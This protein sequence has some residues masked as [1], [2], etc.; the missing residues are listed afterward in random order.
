MLYRRKTYEIDP[1]VYEVFT[2]FFHTYLLPNQLTHGAKLLGRWVNEEK[3]EIMALW[4]YRDREHYE[5]VE[6]GIRA[7]EMHQQAQETR[8]S[9]PRLFITSNETFFTPTGNYE[10][11]KH[12]VS[13][14]GY[15]VNDEGHVLL[16]RNN[17]RH[18]TYEMPGG[19]VEPGET[20]TAALHR[21]V[22]EETGVEAEINEISGVYQNITSGIICIVYKGR[23][24]SGH[25]APQPPETN[26]VRFVDLTKEKIEDWVK[27]PQFE[28]RLRDAHNAQGVTYESFEVRP[29]RLIE[30]STVQH[31]IEV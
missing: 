15:I 11:S 19:Q 25:A 14:S 9:L 7:S 17:H 29:Y 20:L 12:S 21:E 16:V 2:N 30:R 27:A 3:T 1:A 10:S 23:A 28:S 22:L 31:G 13:V 6:Q 18:H 5:E 4:A 24:V 26:D 8:K